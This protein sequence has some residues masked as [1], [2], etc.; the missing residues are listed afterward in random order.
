VSLSGL[1]KA[2]PSMPT[3]KPNWFLIAIYAVAAL[4]V[5]A[6]SLIS[7]QIRAMTYAPLRELLLP[8]PKP[9]TLSVLYST[10]KE[11]WLKDVVSQFEA[12]NTSVN[13]RPIHIE[14]SQMGSREIYLGVMDGSQKPDIISPAGSLQISILQDLSRKKNGVSIVNMNDKATCRSVLTTPLVLVAWRERAD[15]LWGQ[16]PG[17]SLWKQLGQAVT[18]PQ[19]WAAYGHPEWSFVKFGHTDPTKSN[20]GFMTILL[21]TYDYLGKQ[22]GLTQADIL[23]NTGYQEWFKQVEGS[24][25]DFGES[26]GTYMQNI[27]AYGPSKYDIVAVYEATAIEQIEN[28]AG[29]YG[30]LYLYYPPAT[31]L[32]D[33][34]FCILNADWV[35]TDKQAAAKVFLDYLTAPAAQQKALMQY[36]FRPVDPSV[37][38]DQPGSPLIQYAANGVHLDLPP[39][40]ELPSGDVL[41]TLLTFWIRDIQR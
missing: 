26:T 36:A 16:D 3:P 20:S 11:A 37:A 5:F 33:H 32:S 12:E 21:M 15:V 27:V 30:Q 4:F 34:P 18:N 19:G 38:L 31:V 29:R 40:V 22:S 7:P 24:V 23:S 17:S 14:L 8:P 1:E 35:T 13:G 10:E 6:A 41:D 28:A 39:Q 2:L 9:I 25:T